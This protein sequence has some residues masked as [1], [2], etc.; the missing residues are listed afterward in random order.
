MLN[1][2]I[3]QLFYG[4]TQKLKVFIFNNVKK[5]VKVCF[6]D[7]YLLFYMRGHGEKIPKVDHQK[8]RFF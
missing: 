3:T 8:N 6:L 4:K 2:N 5:K 1:K 7:Y